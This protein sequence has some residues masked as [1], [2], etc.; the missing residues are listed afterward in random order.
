MRNYSTA[1]LAIIA[2]ASAT[3]FIAVQNQA[4][5]NEN[6]PAFVH[7]AFSEWTKE[8]KKTYQ[9]PAEYTHR[10]AT[11]YKTFQRVNRL[12]GRV[13]FSLKLNKFSDMSKDELKAKYTGYKPNYR[14]RNYAEQLE[15]S[16]LKQNPKSVD[17]RSK[18]PA[19]KNQKNCG[20]CWSFGASVALEF[21]Y[22]QKG[23]PVTAFSEQQL[24]DCTSKYG[25]AGC[26]GGNAQ[27]AFEYTIAEGIVKMSDYP[28]VARQG[29]CNM[30]GK[31][32]VGKPRDYFDVK[33]NNGPQLEAAVAERVVAVAVDSYEMFNY[34][35]GVFTQAACNY[36]Q[37]DHAVSV[38]GYGK[39][40]A[41]GKDYW[42]MRNSWGTDWGE[43]GYMKLEK[44]TAKS[45]KGTCGVRMDVS[46]VL[47]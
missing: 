37:V 20:S 25:N 30:R 47:F 2:I 10:L 1:A 26:E 21:A 44:N 18:I 23:N 4:M 6:I 42:L 33:P 9:S 38:V 22:V 27:P 36:Q 16:N 43:N 29:P 7:E 46:Y 31:K 24:I 32:I 17:W 12:Q 35:S 39:D 19:V 3:T 13:S 41:T 34:N 5:E 11:F 8:Y 28:Y 40:A 15:G 45:G 14:K